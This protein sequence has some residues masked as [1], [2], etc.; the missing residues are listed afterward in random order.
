[1]Q[2]DDVV[3]EIKTGRIGFVE[4]ID[5]DYYGSQQAFKIYQK[6]PRGFCI[7]SEMVDGIG[8]TKKG[9]RDRIMVCWTD[10]HPEYR[11]SEELE[12]ISEKETHV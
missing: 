5:T 3:R 9:V 7:R 10:G 1:M 12:V 11:S 2:I 4:K 8:P 6:I